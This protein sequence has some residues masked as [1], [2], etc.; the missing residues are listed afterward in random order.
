MLYRSVLGILFVVALLLTLNERYQEERSQRNAEVPAPAS[1]T[2]EE[3]QRPPALTPPSS[4]AQAQTTRPPF[5]PHRVRV[6]RDTDLLKA[7]EPAAPKVEPLAF[8]PAGIPASAVEER[9][10]WYLLDTNLV[11]GW[12]PV[13]AVD[14]P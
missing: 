4:A 6:K 3:G 12:A 5:V 8:V 9:N 7:P 13:E 10:G 11:R 1:R 2:L 14:E